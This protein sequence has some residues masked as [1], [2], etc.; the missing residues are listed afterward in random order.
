ML[1]MMDKK[2]LAMINMLF[3]VNRRHL[4]VCMRFILRRYLRLSNI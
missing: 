3:R 2:T 4:F 1:A